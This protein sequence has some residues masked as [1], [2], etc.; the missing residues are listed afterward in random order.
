MGKVQLNILPPEATEK[1]PMEEL[2]SPAEE[3]LFLSENYLEKCAFMLG[4]DK[5][6]LRK[7]S[8]IQRDRFIRRLEKSGSPEDLDLLRRYRLYAAKEG[9]KPPKKNPAPP[10]LVLVRKDGAL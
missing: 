3:C 10:L 2:L 5:E 1:T 9:K 7:K 8:K 4:I 6:A